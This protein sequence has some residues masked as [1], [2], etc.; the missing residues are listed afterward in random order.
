MLWA[1][2]LLLGERLGPRRPITFVDVK[3]V[4]AGAGKEGAADGSTFQ[5]VISVHPAISEAGEGDTITGDRVLAGG[6]AGVVDAI[7]LGEIARY[8][9]LGSELQDHQ[10]VGIGGEPLGADKRIGLLGARVVFPA[11]G[12][13]GDAKCNGEKNGKELSHKEK[14]MR[15]KQCLVSAFR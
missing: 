13:T 7:G 9:G 2:W 12:E 11:G 6:L 14:G 4:L 10:V 15:V 3:G 5:A 8:V 1:Q